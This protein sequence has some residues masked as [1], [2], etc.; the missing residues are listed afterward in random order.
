MRISITR[1]HASAITREQALAI[2]GRRW[3]RPG[4]PN[5]VYLDTA[6]IIGLNTNTYR[7]GNIRSA[8]IN[9][10]DVSNA[11]ARRILS[12]RLYADDSG[13]HWACPDPPRTVPAENVFAAA[14]DRLNRINA[15]TTPDTDTATT[16][17]AEADETTP[18]TQHGERT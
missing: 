18:N 15:A 5:R 16:P 4:G 6:D 8:T 7:S 2:G 13:L 14:H 3:N 9:G 12:S 17:A 1:K 10:H 11:E